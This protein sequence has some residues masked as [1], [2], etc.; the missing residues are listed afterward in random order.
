MASSRP[1]VSKEWEMPH[2]VTRREAI[3]EIAVLDAAHREERF[4]IAMVAEINCPACG[5]ACPAVTPRSRVAA[6]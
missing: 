5:R 2:R 6:H 1:G 3:F 4:R